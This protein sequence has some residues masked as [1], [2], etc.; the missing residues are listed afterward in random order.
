MVKIQHV[1]NFKM[2][3]IQATVILLFVHTA[4]SNPTGFLSNSMEIGCNKKEQEEIDINTLIT[5]ASESNINCV[6]C[7]CEKKITWCKFKSQLCKDEFMT[8][9]NRKTSQP[10]RLSTKPLTSSSTTASLPIITTTSR[11]QTTTPYVFDY[12]PRTANPNPIFRETLPDTAFPEDEDEQAYQSTTST[13]KPEV[14]DF[15]NLDNVNESRS[16]HHEEQP[17][18][19]PA[20]TT[21]TTTTTTTKRPLARKSKPVA[22]ASR[23]SMKSIMPTAQYSTDQA[24]LNQVWP[25]KSQLIALVWAILPLVLLISSMSA[26]IYYIV[27]IIHSFKKCEDNPKN[28]KPRRVH[29]FDDV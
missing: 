20:V 23:M 7:W 1:S 19:E 17:D 8:R 22:K 3:F 26:M 21:T 18:E 24:G 6:T 9:S 11:P 2:L 13:M 27:K 4:T 29:T 5:T 15:W 14:E 10:V 16:E 25:T 28:V 12:G